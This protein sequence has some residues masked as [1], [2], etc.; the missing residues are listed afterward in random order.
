MS[1]GGGADPAAAAADEARE[2]QARQGEI[3]D[4]TRRVVLSAVL[5]APVLLAVMTVEVF[6]DPHV[7]VEMGTETYEARATH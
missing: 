5:T 4:L 2:A 3:G 7:T 1:G 6:A